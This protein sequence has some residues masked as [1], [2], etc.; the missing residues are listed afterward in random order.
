[1][2][3]T[4]RHQKDTHDGMYPRRSRTQLFHG[5]GEETTETPVWSDLCIASVT[6]QGGKIALTGIGI[7]DSIPQMTPLTWVQKLEQTPL[8]MEWQLSVSYRGSWK[9]S[10]APSTLTQL[11]V[12]NGSFQDQCGA[13]AW[14]I[15]GKTLEDWIEGSMNTPGQKLDHS[16][17]WSEAA[18]IYGALLTVWHFVQEY[19]TKGTIT[20]AC[21]GRSVLDH[22][23]SKKSIDPFAVHADLLHA[24]KNIQLQMSCTIKLVHI[25]GHQDR[26][27]PTVL[28]REAWLNIEADLMAKSH[29]D[30]GNPKHPNCPLPFEPWRL[31][32]SNEKVTK[33]HH[34]AIRLAMNGPAAQQYWREKIH[35]HKRNQ[36]WTCRQ[37]R[38]C[39]V[40]AHWVGDD[41]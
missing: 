39:L 13:C 10:D 17:F 40:R 32:I 25:K 1:M 12:S 14:I 9:T 18:G 34:W 28:S 8:G 2:S 31:L 26:G 27:Y 5:I 16:S 11:A 20:V 29:I 30:S 22:L 21:D 19:P 41:G 4:T 6:P 3:C 23:K 7:S 24:S 15:K 37:W 35:L 38:E 33:Q 36:R